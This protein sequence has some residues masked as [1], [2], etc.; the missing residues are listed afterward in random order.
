MAIAKLCRVVLASPKSDS[1]VLLAKLC[2]FSFFHPS[3]REGLVEDPQL[4]FL[5]SRIH[6]VYSEA[7][8]LL[9]EQHL[10][11]EKAHQ[12]F[13]A[14]D[15]PS[16]ADALTHEMLELK[17][18][19]Q[20]QEL[21]EERKAE[22]YMRLFAL[23]DAAQLSFNNVRRIRVFPGMKR[24][25]VIEGFV[26]SDVL[27]PFR[28]KLHDYI[29]SIEPVEK[30]LA[31]EPYIPT[32]IINPK[33]ISLFENI[34]LVQGLPRYNEIDPTPIIALVFPLF[35]GIM[36]ADLGR[37]L[38][39]LTVGLFMASKMQK[40]GN[41]GRMLAILGSSSFVMG[42][43]TGEAFGLRIS[44]P[45]Q[46][47]VPLRSA[48]ENPTSI[49]SLLFLFEMAAV[50]GTFHIATAYAIAIIN[51]IRSRNRIEA[52]LGHLP[53]LLLYSSSIA[54]F[55]A[56]IGVQFRFQDVFT[57]LSP[58]PL[59]RGLLG[60]QIPTSLVAQISFPIF[61]ASFLT[62]V[63]GRALA[64]F[65]MHNDRH[66]VV[67]ALESGLLE[68]ILKPIEFLAN[69]ISYIRLGALL[70][71][72]IILGSLATRVL[73]LGLLGIPIFVLVN[74]GLIAIEGLIVYVQDLRLHLYEWLSKFYF[75]LGIPFSPLVSRG[76]ISEIRWLP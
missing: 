52:L 32:L 21:G 71:L 15:L 14:R 55:L 19:L 40:Y 34:T 68:G 46:L 41:W 28:Q 48:L 57:S 3:D 59:F 63:H 22:I 45:F 62:M 72:S 43:F 37:G 36:L 66:I 2:E 6:L 56:L 16:L 60:I 75:G 73:E 64:Y 23:R 51:Q 20:T 44:T 30:R 1:G 39:L 47:I 42:L 24:T 26:P 12:T 67:E 70:I 35:F 17:E 31:R 25:I 33:I 4:L 58:T 7:N 38:V 8:E 74:L 13:Q 69:T 11:I 10:S 65:I 9:A 29:I 27:Q 49:E 18:E 76:G 5:V 53:T 61:I 54:L 50:I